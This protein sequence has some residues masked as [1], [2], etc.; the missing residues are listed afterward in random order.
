MTNTY[1]D[2]DNKK[3]TLRICAMSMKDMFSIKYI[4]RD[5]RRDRE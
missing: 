1:Q 5:N 3:Y 4:S 2:R